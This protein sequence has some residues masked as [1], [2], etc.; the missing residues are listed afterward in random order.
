MKSGSGQQKDTHLCAGPTQAKSGKD[1][2][3]IM[4]PEIDPGESDKRY[5]GI[6]GEGNYREE[7]T[8]YNCHDRGTG[9]MTGWKT[10]LIWWN[11]PV[12]DPWQLDK[13]PISFDHILDKLVNGQLTGE[14]SQ[15]H[16]QKC[17][18]LSRMG[19]QQQHHDE[20]IVPA[21]TAA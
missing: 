16:T 10:E 14:R 9:S 1:I 7:V 17:E 8:E 2:R 6:N 18:R 19:K 12:Q 21:I 11:Y 15:R 13:R 20:R 5:P 4:N 3:G